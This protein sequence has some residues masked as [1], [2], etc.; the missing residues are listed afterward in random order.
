MGTRG[1]GDKQ[2]KFNTF[3]AGVKMK[4]E[5]NWQSINSMIGQLNPNIRAAY[6]LAQREMAEKLLKIVKGHIYNQDLG[7]VPLSPSTIKNKDGND[8]AYIDTGL[9]LKSIKIMTRGTR[10]SVGIPNNLQSRDGVYLSDIASIMEYGAGNVP[11]RPLWEPSRKE[12]TNTFI[13]TLFLTRLSGLIL[14]RYGILPEI[15]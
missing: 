11:A 8:R 2:L 15:R 12:L 3:P 7:W 10:I 6:I 9:F 4:L 1:T 13:K 14:K 5:G